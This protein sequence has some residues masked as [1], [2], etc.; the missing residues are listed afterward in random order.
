MEKTKQDIRELA[1]Q[2][3]WQILL[4]HCMVMVFFTGLKW[5]LSDYV[6]ILPVLF[7]S[8]C[9]TI[10]LAE[11]C[12]AIQRRTLEYWPLLTQAVFLVSRLIVVGA[13]LMVAVLFMVFNV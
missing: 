11:R 10:C 9:N 8:F 1:V 3:I 5:A 13:L 6:A 4:F 12:W 2:Q 7:V